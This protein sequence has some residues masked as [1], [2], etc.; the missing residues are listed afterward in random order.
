MPRRFSM[1][2]V[3]NVRV[4]NV[5]AK[6]IAVKKTAPNMR[7]IQLEKGRIV[8]IVYVKAAAISE[9]IKIFAETSSPQSAHNAY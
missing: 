6:K 7:S 1:S 5:A 8:T 2:P 3:F 9:D 4:N